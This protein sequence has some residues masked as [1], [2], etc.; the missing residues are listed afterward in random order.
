MW[1]MRSLS[2]S[3]IA[4][5]VSMAAAPLNAGADEVT[6]PVKAVWQVQEIYLSY[7]GLTTYYSCDGLRDKVRTMITQLGAAEGSVVN[8]AGCTELS[9]PERLPGAR[10]II[11]TPHAATPEMIEAN[12]KDAKR[13]E[14]LAKLQ[15]KGKPALETGEFD[16]VRKVVSL[17]SKDPTGAGGAG[18]CELVEHIRD[19]VVKKMDARVVKDDLHC[20]PHQGTIGNRKLQVEVLAK[21]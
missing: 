20:T 17:N 12:A 13:S 14:L 9:G 10:I 2:A 1:R 7:F 8:A 18:D 3:G 15:R 21:S 6:S 4:L 5:A 16:A 11:A 19:Q